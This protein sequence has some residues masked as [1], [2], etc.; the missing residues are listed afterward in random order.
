MDT[1]SQYDAVPPEPLP[2]LHNRI[3]HAVFKASATPPGGMPPGT[4]LSSGKDPMSQPR[5][6]HPT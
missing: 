3:S 2:H 1:A 4:R 6:E 5:M